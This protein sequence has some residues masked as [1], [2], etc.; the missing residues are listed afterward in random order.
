MRKQRI[1]W[2][3]PSIMISNH[4]PRL[5]Q[6]GKDLAW[7]NANCIFVEINKQ[8]ATVVSKDPIDDEDSELQIEET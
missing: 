8:I 2:R 4:D 3:K 1:K 5:E 7:L 6:L